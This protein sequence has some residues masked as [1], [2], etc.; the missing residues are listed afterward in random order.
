[1]ELQLCPECGV[2]KIVTGEHLWLNNGDI[3]HSRAQSTRIIFL[4]TENLDPLFHGIEQIISVPIEHMVITSSRRAYRIYLNAFVPEFIREKIQ[5]KEI[6]YEPYDAAFREVAG[7]N[8][9]GRYKEVSHR[10]EKDED[11]YDTVTIS[12]P[13][14]VPMT[15]AAHV[16]AIEC[17]TG[18]DQGYKCEE[19]SNSEYKITTFPSPHLEELKERLWFQP[20]Q[21][22]NGDLEL[23]RCA[24][25]GGPKV[26]GGYQW[27]PE[28]GIIINKITRRRMSI[29]GNE[30]MEPVFKE[31]E[32]E[33]GDIIPRAVVEAQRRFTKGGFF[34]M[35]DITEEG[36]FRTQLALRGLGNLKEL[37]MKRKGMQ[38]RL[39]NV[40]L[41]LIVIGLAQGLFEMGFGLDE[42]DVDWEIAEDGVLEMEVK[43]GS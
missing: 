18:V 34:T 15:V 37:T 1:L 10:Y 30:L 12:E 25:C 36:D 32:Q 21:H 27:F 13:F 20:Y 11:D 39:D 5:L 24:T 4:E 7:L 26:L 9:C 38:M 29:S 23:E 40:A 19:V 14:C 35:E 28:R 6:D 2:P 42:S 16:G 8:G 43:P 41:P 31:L 33:L 17:L 3:V 22:R